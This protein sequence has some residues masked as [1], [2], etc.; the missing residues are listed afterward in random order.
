LNH[1]EPRC[2]VNLPVNDLERPNALYTA[3]G[4]TPSAEAFANQQ[5]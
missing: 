4:F 2:F 1:D 3:I 5:A